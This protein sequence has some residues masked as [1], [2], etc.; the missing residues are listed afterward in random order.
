LF[1]YEVALT[2]IRRGIDKDYLKSA[3]IVKAPDRRLCS[4]HSILFLFID[5]FVN[6]KILSLFYRLKDRGIYST[7]IPDNIAF[8]W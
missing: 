5:N 6:Y 7:R 8:D 2:S 1:E 4:T 3:R